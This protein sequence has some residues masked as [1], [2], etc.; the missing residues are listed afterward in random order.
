VFYG[1]RNEDG[2]TLHLFSVI[3]RTN[4]AWALEVHP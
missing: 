3:E 2:D 1:K 4:K